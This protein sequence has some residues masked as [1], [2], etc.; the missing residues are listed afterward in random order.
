MLIVSLA[1]GWALGGGVAERPLDQ[2]LADLQ[3]ATVRNDRSAIAGMVHY[4]IKVLASGWI[5]PIDDRATFA[6]YFDAFFTDEIRDLIAAAA[7]RP[8]TRAVPAVVKLGGD[9]IRIMRFDGRFKIIG[10]TVP[11]ASGRVRGARRGTT[12]V[13]FRTGDNSAAFTGSLAA[14]EHERYIVHASRNELLDVRVDR[15]R[16]RDVIAHVLA[17]ST[18]S[19]LDARSGDGAR[20]WTGRVPATGDYFID[21]MRTTPSGDAVLTYWLTVSV[22]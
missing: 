11:P 9:N 16:G 3:A 4:P 21:V 19:P 12:V 2:F 18:Q 13:S 17:V 15:V 8:G 5:I 10:I 14:G 6:R 22:R 20:V 7:E 1:L